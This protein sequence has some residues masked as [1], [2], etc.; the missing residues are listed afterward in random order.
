MER[1]NKTI[2]AI[3]FIAFLMIFGVSAPEY[4]QAE[5][6]KVVFALDY[7]VY[8]KHAPHFVSVKRGFFKEEGLDV[9]IERGRGSL[10]A[11]QKVAMG[12]AQFG[13]ADSGTLINARSK[14]AMAKTVAMIHAKALQGVLYLS[15]SGIKA[16]KDFEGRTLGGP[17]TTSTWT[18]FPG[19]A[20]LAGF[21]VKKVN[22]ITMDAA[23]T[24]P[25]LMA[26]K[27]DGVPTFSLVMPAHIKAAKE[28]GQEVKFMYYADYGL[29]IY[30]NGI[31]TSDEIIAKNPDLVQ[32]FIRASVKG[33]AWSIENPQKA[34][35]DLIEL[36]PILTRDIASE[37]F[38]LMIEHLYDGLSEKNGIMVID[39]KKMQKTIDIIKEAFKIDAPIATK[40]IYTKD[41]VVN[42]PKDLLFPKRAK[43]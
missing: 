27:I 11:V 14:G 8:G 30:N 2:L 29:D 35:D 24:K 26:G 13:H 15:K 31:I 10:E 19:F 33:F 42:L 17:L 34:V 21:D 23:A 3:C 4:A 37:E 39:E 12:K 1:Y 36:N 18:M 38:K 28:I 32:R 5:A 25:S 22:Y 6:T 16:P 40:D 43:F 7:V 41:F 20:K 9:E